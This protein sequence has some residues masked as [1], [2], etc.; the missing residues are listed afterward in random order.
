M[1]YPTLNADLNNVFHYFDMETD[2]QGSIR[3]KPASDERNEGPEKSC[4]DWKKLPPA[5]I[6]DVKPIIKK[7]TE[8]K[9]A[10]WPTWTE[11][12]SA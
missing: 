4:R 2:A 8:D 10:A 7:V 12:K 6:A 11:K 9:K 3:K 1:T 5:I